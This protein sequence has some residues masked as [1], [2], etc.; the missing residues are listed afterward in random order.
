[1]A[2]VD[3]AALPTMAPTFNAARLKVQLKLSSNRLRMLQQKKAAQNAAYRL[4]ISKLLEKHKLESA[5]I[6]VR[7]HIH[8]PAP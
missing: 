8:A 7:A 4:E 6:R 1:M 5:R 3:I 2:S